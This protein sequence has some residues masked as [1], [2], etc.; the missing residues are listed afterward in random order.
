MGWHNVVTKVLKS[1]DHVLA[2][3]RGR[4]DYRRMVREMQHDWLCRRERGHKQR[5]AGS[6]YKLEEARK[7]ILP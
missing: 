6:L 4:Y 5:K 2:V 3:I 1:R 7:W